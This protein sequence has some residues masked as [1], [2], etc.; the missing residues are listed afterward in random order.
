MI[1]KHLHV[2]GS[3]SIP[4]LWELIIQSGLK[5]TAKNYW[6]FEKTVLMDKSNVQSLDDYLSILHRLEL[7]QSAPQALELCFYDTFK[8]C[9]L[10]GVTEAEI[11]W[12]PLK[13]SANGT[14]DLDRLIVAARSG[15]ERAKMTYGIKGG[16]IFCLGRDLTEVENSAIWKMAMRYNGKGVHGID[17]A[18]PEH[19]PLMQYAELKYIYSY[20]E[21]LNMQ[22]TI[23]CAETFTDHTEAE[24]EYVLN[25]LKPNRIGHGIQCHRFPKLLEMAAR[26]KLHFEICISSNL[27]TKAVSSL[28][29]F[30]KIFKK[31]EKYGIDYSVNTDSTFLLRTT[32]AREHKLLEE[33]KKIAKHA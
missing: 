24:L 15:Y 5:T 28:E 17:V 9:Y 18:G 30:A 8:H 22:R 27:A 20:A 32:L 3:T 2:S 29:E 21:S 16:M 6:D 31:F 23:H 11:R 33:I 4:L 26:Q 1:E 13:R 14:L 10:S 7:A 25:V 19:K 12:N